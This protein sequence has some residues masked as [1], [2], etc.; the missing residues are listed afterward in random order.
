MSAAAVDV[1]REDQMLINE[2]GRLN[3]Q[4]RELREDRA[5]LQKRLEEVDDATTEL[6][7]GDGDDVRERRR[8]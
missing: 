3:A 7:M 6:A 5:L 2:F 1:R 8:I 4:A